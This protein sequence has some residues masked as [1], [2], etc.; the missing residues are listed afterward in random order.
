MPHRA[1]VAERAARAAEQ[2][3]SSKSSKGT[4]GVSMKVVVIWPVLGFSLTS[5]ASFT[6]TP[7]IGSSAVM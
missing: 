3:S 7:E 5:P 1:G 2:N 4:C 6:R